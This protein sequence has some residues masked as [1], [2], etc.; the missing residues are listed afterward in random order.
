MYGSSRRAAAAHAAAREQERYDTRAGDFRATR[1]WRTGTT[2]FLA[3]EPL[4]P[5]GRM[6]EGAQP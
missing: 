4:T 3:M 1:P 5:T 6:L 2:E